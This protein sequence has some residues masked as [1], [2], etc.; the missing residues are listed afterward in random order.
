MRERERREEGE[1]GEGV[2]EN[3]TKKHMQ[4]EDAQFYLVYLSIK[5]GEEIIE[6]P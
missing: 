6:R 1:R 5:Y 4:F 2:R 3:R